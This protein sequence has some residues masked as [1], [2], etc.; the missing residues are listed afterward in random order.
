MINWI[1]GWILRCDQLTKGDATIDIFSLPIFGTVVR[2]NA[3]NMEA[4]EARAF[5]RS[6]DPDNKMTMHLYLEDGQTFHKL[7]PLEDD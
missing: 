1:L 5:M 6:V 2:V 3:Y 4:W 7:L